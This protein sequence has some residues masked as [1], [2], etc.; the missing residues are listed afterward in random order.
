MDRTP[1]FTI[2]RREKK[3]LGVCSGLGKKFGIDPTVI[4]IGVIAA[5]I[6]L[7]FKWILLAYV[8]AAL[9]G[10]AAKRTSIGRGRTSEFDRMGETPRRGS[11]RD[12]REH[13]DTTDRKM[14]SVD[15][16][17]NTPQN[18]ELARQIEALRRGEEIK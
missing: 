7:S 14:M 2:D 1:L 16:H 12:A 18:D 8:A 4:R 13:L 3:L 11:M 6:L 17:L 10:G 9:L 5:A 15:H